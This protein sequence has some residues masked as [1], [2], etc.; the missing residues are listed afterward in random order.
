V[1]EN[2]FTDLQVSSRAH[3]WL[4]RKIEKC[5]LHRRN[6][7]LNLLT[8]KFKKKKRK[9]RE[10][11]IAIDLSISE[12]L[13][14]VKRIRRCDGENNSLYG[15]CQCCPSDKYDSRWYFSQKY[16]M[17][18]DGYF[19]YAIRRHTTNTWNGNENSLVF[20]RVA[21]TISYRWVWCARLWVKC[22]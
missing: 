6:R 7:V 1:W 17:I 22:T 13:S 11:T 4:L 5:Q 8:W 3:E 18:E 20:R 12:R 21:P 16:T 19:D 2:F 15:I 9:E 14:E 10:H